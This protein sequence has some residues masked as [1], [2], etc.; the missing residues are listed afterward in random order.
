[1]VWKITLKN[2]II[3]ILASFFLFQILSMIIS[4]LFPSVPVFQ[5]GF[6]ILLMLLCVGLISLFVLAINLEQLKQKENLIFIVIVFGLVILGYIYIPVYFPSL[7]S[8]SPQASVAIKQTVGQI[9]S[10]FGG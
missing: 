7:F 6:A 9:F 3:A 5:G 8:I 2:S 1:M 10:A 4:S